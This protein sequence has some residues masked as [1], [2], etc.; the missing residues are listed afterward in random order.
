MDITVSISDTV[1]GCV[2][3]PIE[4]GTWGWTSPT[5]PSTPQPHERESCM[6]GVCVCAHWCSCHGI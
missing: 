6:A 4:G 3:G 5:S 2:S 1:E